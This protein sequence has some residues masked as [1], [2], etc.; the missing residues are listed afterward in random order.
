MM[1]INSRTF[2]R[3]DRNEKIKEAIEAGYSKEYITKCVYEQQG[4]IEKENR[5]KKEE[6]KKLVYTIAFEVYK[7]NL[8]TAGA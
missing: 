4:G 6:C 7:N 5:L 2:L 1:E 3:S 8:K